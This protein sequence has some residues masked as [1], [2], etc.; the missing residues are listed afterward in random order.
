MQVR[1]YTA[2]LTSGRPSK[3]IVANLP[4]CSPPL[5]APSL[6]SRSITRLLLTREPTFIPPNG[7]R[8]QANPTT[9]A[10]RLFT[11]LETLRYDIESPRWLSS[12]LPPSSS[13][14]SATVVPARCVN[15][16]SRGLRCAFID[17]RRLPH[18]AGTKQLA[19]ESEVGLTRLLSVDHLRQAPLDW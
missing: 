11:S 2:Q 1:L 9:L 14:L 4:V 7:R 5:L 15:T 3:G 19:M 16:A 17:G 18:L 6:Y 8:S 13:C 12:R 10:P